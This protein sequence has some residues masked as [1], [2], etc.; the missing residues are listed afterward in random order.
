MK[1]GIQ[2]WGSRGDINPWIA[3]GQGL[4]QAG[5]DV[6]LYYTS[7]LSAIDLS[8]FSSDGLTV[9]STIEFSDS[10]NIYAKIKAR[11]IYQMDMFEIDSY[12]RNEIF[13]PFKNE[14]IRACEKLCESC[15]LIISN[16]IL[17]QVHTIAEKHKVPL[18]YV[19]VDN[20]FTPYNALGHYADNAMNSIMGEQ[21]NLFREQYGLPR[22]RNV[23]ADVY[24]SNILNLLAYSHIFGKEQ[25]HWDS[26]Y[27]ICGYLRISHPHNI[28]IPESLAD[29]LEMGSKPVFFSMGS[30][31]FFEGNNFEILDIFLE[32]INLCKCRAIIQADW[33]S[34]NC[35]IPQNPNIYAISYL[36]HELIFPHCLGVVHHGGAGT[37]HTCLFEGVPSVVIAY[38]WDQFYWGH[39]L[40]KLGA[41]PGMLKRKYLDALQ[42]AGEISKLMADNE[43]SIKTLDAK[44]KIKREKGVNKAVR[45][46]EDYIGRHIE[47]SGKPQNNNLCE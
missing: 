23:R 10:T 14:I 4:Q 47:T 16:P 33:N 3:L 30:I 24:N 42:L 43:Y 25:E 29:F 2:T 41:S 20:Y 5:H 6:C 9:V 37:T 28:T 39:E 40:V 7:S 13:E 44:R 21:I 19:L 38:A 27:K 31:A 36:P 15:E 32:A 12:M 46:L 26:K 45:L 34:I 1:I 22:V 35:Q 11:K 8:G 17:Y 18:I